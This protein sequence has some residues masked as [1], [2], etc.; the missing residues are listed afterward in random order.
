MLYNFSKLGELGVKMR[1]S[2]NAVFGYWGIPCY[3]YLELPDSC[4]LDIR[5]LPR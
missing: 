4:D 1:P 2:P 3:T 5:I